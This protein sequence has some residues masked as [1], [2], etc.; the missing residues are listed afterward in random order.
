MQR[1]WKCEPYWLMHKI[2]VADVAILKT[3]WQVDYWM[4]QVVYNWLNIT[5]ISCTNE[6][7]GGQRRKTIKV[8]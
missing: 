5:G 8:V 4:G 7:C 6:V 3:N 1:N 2:K